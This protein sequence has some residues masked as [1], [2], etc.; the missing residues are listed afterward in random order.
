M[1]DGY[2]E[3][4]RHCMNNDTVTLFHAAEWRKLLHDSTLNRSL[5]SVIVSPLL[6]STWDQDDPYNYYAPGN[7]Q[8]THCAAGC[9]AVAMGQVMNYWKYPVWQPDR[10]KQID[11]CNM[12]DQLDPFGSTLEEIDA[13]A[14]LLYE[15][16]LS[17]NM[18]YCNGGYGSSAN[19][20]DVRDALVNQFGYSNDADFQLRFWHNNN[21]WIGRIKNNLNHSWPVIY[22]GRSS[23]TGGS[24]HAFV[25]DGY[26]SDDR[27]HFNFGWGGSFDGYF[28]LDNLTPT[29]HNYNY[30]QGAIF[31]IYP[32]GTQ[33]YCPFRIP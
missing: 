8:F 20:Q 22:R 10:I 21:T 12:T 27:F 17:V 1:I 31:Y 26:D 32:S 29:G 30:L 23:T 18:C 14:G 24:G 4:I 25:C 28:T 16:G 3:E 2:L 9:V 6:T 19:T 13:V 7:N 33:D 15:C 5:T 11:W